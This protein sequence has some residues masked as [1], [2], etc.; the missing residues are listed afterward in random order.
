MSNEKKIIP[1][2]QPFFDDNLKSNVLDCIDSGWISSKGKYIKEFEDDFSS[3]LNIKYSTSVSNGT[4]ALHLALKALEIDNGDEVIVPTFTYIASVNAISYVGALPVFVDS[5]FQSWNIDPAKIE[6]KISIKTKAIMVV[7]I[8]GNP[9]D[10]NTI[11]RIA[12]K[13]NLYVIED[14]A[15]AFG[16]KYMNKSLGSFGDVSTFSFFGNKTITTGEGGMVSS[17]SKKLID[18]INLL[19]NQAVSNSIEYWHTEI[20][21]N[22]RMTNIAAAIGVAQLKSADYILQKKKQIFQWYFEQ[23]RELP[24]NFQYISKESQSSYWMISLILDNEEDRNAVRQL[25]L[26][27]GIET[28][29]FFYPAHSMKM[30]SESGRFVNEF[31][32][33]NALSSRG[34]NLPSFPELSF[35]EVLYIS[36]IINSYYKK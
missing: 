24:L 15:E 18:K 32:V 1:I 21:F 31:P 28:R 34:M 35:E 30:Y 7:H 27:N 25:L 17:N 16:S 11:M 4:T 8:Y 19:K 2:Y 36:K 23:L 14:V 22:Y 10:M 29:P 13:Y 33:S 26:E 3:F 20:G 6:E 5:D 9:C 12:R